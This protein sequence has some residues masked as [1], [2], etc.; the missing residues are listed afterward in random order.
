MGLHPLVIIPE[1]MF[2]VVGEAVYVTDVGMFGRLIDLT[3]SGCWIVKFDEGGYGTVY[4]LT[5]LKSV[6]YIN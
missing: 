4:D 2:F 6:A 1:P 5:V 3:E